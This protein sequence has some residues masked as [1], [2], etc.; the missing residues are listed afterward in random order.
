MLLNPPALGAAGGYSLFS[1]AAAPPPPQPHLGGGSPTN[2]PAA[3]PPPPLPRA[4]TS[5]VASPNLHDGTSSLDSTPTLGDRATLFATPSPDPAS[6]FDG[7]TKLMP[8]VDWVAARIRALGGVATS[9]SLGS[10]LAVESA[11]NYNMIKVHFGGLCGLLS[12]YPER[13]RLLH[14]KPLNHVAVVGPAAVSSSDDDVPQVEP[15]WL[16]QQRRA[17]PVERATREDEAAVVREVVNILASA[18][19]NALTAVDLSN[20][21]R[22]RL[23]VGALSRVRASHGGLL[24]F[25]EK[26]AGRVRVVRVPKHDVVTLAPVESTPVMPG[27]LRAEAAVFSPQFVEPAVPVVDDGKPAPKQ[28]IGPA[29]Q[30]PMGA[31]SLFPAPPLFPQQLSQGCQRQLARLA[32]EDYA[33]TM[34]WPRDAVH[35]Q[36]IVRTVLEC[37]RAQSPRPST[38]HKIRAYLRRV[39]ALQSS[40]KSVPLRALLTAYPQLFVIDGTSVAER[41]RGQTPVPSF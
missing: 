12:R 1:G 21:L 6:M 9:A 41:S 4:P 2:L 26:S 29:R 31:S 5:H 19:E 18:S 25:L 35:D 27:A 28:C 38:L 10:T 20:A 30:K 36:G 16:R 15:R 3:A 7:D 11:E 32:A 34:P 23:G 39:Y 37:L 13:F 14:D 24:T 22:A 8:Y 40:V 33:P 17:A